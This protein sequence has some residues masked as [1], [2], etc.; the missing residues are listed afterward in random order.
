MLQLIKTFKLD[1][2]NRDNIKMILHLISVPS[3]PIKL[4]L[5]ERI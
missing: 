1:C 5:T 4:K 3:Q 2:E